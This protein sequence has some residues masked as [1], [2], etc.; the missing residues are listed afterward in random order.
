[1]T[2]FNVADLPPALSDGTGSV[3]QLE[4]WAHQVN[5]YNSPEPI[6]LNNS[7][8]RVSPFVQEYGR[9]QQGENRDKPFFS[10]AFNYILG[11]YSSELGS[12]FWKSV[13]DPSPDGS[14]PE[15]LKV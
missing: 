4:A 14:V 6:S 10:G 3:A 8:I 15:E 13:V 5:V 1:M 7:G 12:P 11:D 9:I 2:I